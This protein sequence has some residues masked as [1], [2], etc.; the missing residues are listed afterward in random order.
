VIEA[1]GLARRAI[2]NCLRGQPDMTSDPKIQRC[3]HELMR[4]AQSLCHAL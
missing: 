4:D 1:C 3:K 2:E